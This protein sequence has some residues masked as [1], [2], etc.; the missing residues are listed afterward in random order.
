MANIVSYTVG[1]IFGIL[2][3]SF[4]PDCMMVTDDSGY[5]WRVCNV[6]YKTG[7]KVEGDLDAMP[8]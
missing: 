1:F 5:E 3:M 4:Q 8:E 2:A 7:R 6:S